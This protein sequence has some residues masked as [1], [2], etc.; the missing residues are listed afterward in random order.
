MSDKYEYLHFVYKGKYENNKIY[1]DEVSILSN[2]LKET[3][4]T[5]N[6]SR[7]CRTKRFLSY[8]FQQYFARF[9]Q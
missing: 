4:M 3:N 6:F 1:G 2:R 7:T 9:V 5:S 8:C